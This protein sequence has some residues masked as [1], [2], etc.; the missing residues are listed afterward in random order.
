MSS[1]PLAVVAP[2]FNEG[3]VAVRFVRELEQVLAQL[4]LRSRIVV[5]DDAST[6]D[7][8]ARLRALQ[9]SG[10]RVGIEVLS[11]HYNMGHQEAIYQGLLRAREIGA[12][13]IV[14]MDSDG[15]DDPQAIPAMLSAA[16]RGIVLVNRGR[17][18]ES[19]RFKIGYALYKR[20]F[21]LVT[22]RRISFGNFSMIDRALL[23]V[24][25]DRGFVHYAAF[26]SRQRA[27][28]AY[29]TFDRR[30]RLDGRSKM[31][32][33]SLSI[34]AF[35]SLIE[36]SEDVL[37]LFL[38]LF[39]VLAV[40]AVLSIGTIIG[41]K[42]LTTLA[43]PGWASILTVSLINSTLLCLGFFSIGLL[44]ANS[45]HRRERAGRALYRVVDHAR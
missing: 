14:V 34:H 9:P 42:L 32:F 6:D 29:V 18:R 45:L 24:V 20:M 19:L 11:L 13:R 36:Y 5:V 44:L 40:L 38:K 25:I 2:C 28:T 31:S 7:T 8:L 27:A 37:A 35:R 39:F 3:E 26:L 4:P 1:L 15:E 33:R 16:D 30:A 43:I 21:R 23:D 41:V 17:R 12:E 22:R 10:D